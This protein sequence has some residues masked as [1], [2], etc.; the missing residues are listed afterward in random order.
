MND[1]DSGKT[2]FNLSTIG[3]DD[4]RAALF[5]SLD[6]KNRDYFACDGG[7][8]DPPV[9]LGLTPSMFP[10]KLPDPPTAILYITADHEHMI[11]LK[12][13]IHVKEV[14]DGKKNPVNLTFLKCVL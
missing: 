14:V 12:H 7:C 5:V 11:D 1:S 6:K 9:R 3:Q 8:L 4:N 2:G 10:V 13:T